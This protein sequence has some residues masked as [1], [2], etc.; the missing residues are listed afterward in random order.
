MSMS[1]SLL[2]A[3]LIDPIR[4]RISSHVVRPTSPIS[5]SISPPLSNCNAPEKELEIRPFAAVNLK[6]QKALPRLGNGPAFQVRTRIRESTSSSSWH[7]HR[8]A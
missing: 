4:K 8:I 5:A 3:R 2:V 6:I 7:Q 1:R